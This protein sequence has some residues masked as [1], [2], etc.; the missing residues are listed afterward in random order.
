M[1]PNPRN[2][3]DDFLNPDVMRTRLISTSIYIAA[4]E[5]L[6]D[7]IIE[8]PRNF[9]CLGF[10]KDENI[11]DSDYQSDVLSRNR[12]PLHASI[13]WLMENGAMSAADMAAFDRVKTCRNHLA[14]RLL[15][16]LGNE[17]MPLDFEKCFQEMVGLL[18]KLE[19]WWITNVDIPTNPDL[20]GQKIEE[21][22]IQPGPVLMLKLLYDI[23]LGSEER[24][25]FYHEE[26]K[27]RHGA[28][29]GEQHGQCGG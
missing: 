11:V 13:D 23:A 21:D 28:G 8:R 19:L 9:L 20:D 24:S 12:S 3:W 4:F 29:G 17:G 15:H 16:F 26:F 22:D 7:S 6:K 10:D 14:H 2:S 5:L 25:R 18:R 1:N 27:K